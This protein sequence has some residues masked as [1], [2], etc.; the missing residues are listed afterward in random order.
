MSIPSTD[1]FPGLFLQV[2]A[3][4]ARRLDGRVGS[5]TEI[6]PPYLGVLFVIGCN[7]GIRQGLCADSLGYDATTFGRYVDRL[8]REGLV[9]RDIPETDR[10]AISLTL[11]EEGREIVSDCAPMAQE[12]DEEVRAR[13][14]AAEW[15]KLSELLERFLDVYDHPL[16][17]ILRRDRSAL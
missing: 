12:I 13:M 5:E 16:P 3:R 15:E 7:P 10:R 9:L 1:S 2:A 14:G 17:Q 8:V 6:K 4:F 11:T